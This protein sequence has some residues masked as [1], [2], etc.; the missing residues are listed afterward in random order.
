MKMH[1]FIRKYSKDQ[2]YYVGTATPIEYK[3]ENQLGLS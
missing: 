3:G 2:F 1:L